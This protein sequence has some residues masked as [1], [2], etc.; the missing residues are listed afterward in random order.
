ME[1]FDDHIFDVITKLQSNK[2]QPNEDSVYYDILKMV[3]SL[4]VKQL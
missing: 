1:Q 4:T 3:A 2:R